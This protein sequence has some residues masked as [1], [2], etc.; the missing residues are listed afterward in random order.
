M[1]HPFG[2]PRYL[3]QWHPSIAHVN[4]HRTDIWVIRKQRKEVDTVSGPVE[5]TLALPDS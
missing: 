1:I 5:Q 3:E 2:S 4:V